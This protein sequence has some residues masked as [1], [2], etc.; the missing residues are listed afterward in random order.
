LSVELGK[1]GIAKIHPIP[2]LSAFEQEQMKEAVVALQ[3]NIE[4][5]VK[6]MQGS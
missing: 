3:A 1:E 5:G 6:F 2:A 4:T